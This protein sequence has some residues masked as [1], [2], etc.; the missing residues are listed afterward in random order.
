M[1]IEITTLVEN[2]QG[3]HTALIIEHGLSFL[4]ETE[5]TSV[6]FDTGRSEALLANAKKLGKNLDGVEH[7]VLSHGHY[8]HSGGFSSFVQSRSDR[9][10]DLITGEGFFDKKYARFNASYQYLGNDFDQQYLLRR[11]IAHQTVKTVKEVADGVF[12]VGGFKRIHTEET[13][14]SRFVLPDGDQWKAD[15]F[16][17]EVLMVV[18][19]N[20]GL[21]V[22]VGCSHP[23]ILNMIDHVKETFKK[24]IY[25]LLGGTHLVEADALRIDQTLSAFKEEGIAVLGINHCSGSL[26]IE[27]ATRGSKIHFENTTGSSLIL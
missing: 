16:E 2:N 26:A 3:E 14:H 22:I 10:F 8:D 6:L 7:V 23:G 9:C 21:I 15:L 4:I 18:E 20:K 27:K 19:S 12:V 24:P 13:I 11:G 5:K 1:A 25:A 17:D